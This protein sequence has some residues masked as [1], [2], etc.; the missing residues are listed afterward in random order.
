[1][2]FEI[3]ALG[4]KR[5]NCANNPLEFV[6]CDNKTAH[7]S[8]IAI[9]NKDDQLGVTHSDGAYYAVLRASDNDI[10]KG[11]SANPVKTLRLRYDA[12]K[13]A[14]SKRTASPGPSLF[15]PVGTGG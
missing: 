14:G 2:D 7:V 9:A 12:W 10:V 6:P 4:I 3:N 1:M 8:Y 5:C 11:E 13:R 15:K